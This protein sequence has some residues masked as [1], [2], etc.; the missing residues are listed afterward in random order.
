MPRGLPRL[1]LRLRRL[2]QRRSS[3]LKTRMRT[4][5][6][7]LAGPAP[8]SPLLPH[9]PLAPHRPP[10][11]LSPRPPHASVSIL[12]PLHGAYAFAELAGVAT[13]M[14]AASVRRV[15][16]ARRGRCTCE[17][18]VNPTSSGSRSEAAACSAFGAGLFPSS[19]SHADRRQE[20]TTIP[21]I[22]GQ[23]GFWPFVIFLLLQRT[24]M[25]ITNILFI[26]DYG[27][28]SPPSIVSCLLFILHH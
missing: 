2:S 14:A 4:R 18:R 5:R 22:W 21:S 1:R 16:T 12:P 7:A 15:F 25:T 13:I 26:R 28:C 8:P 23:F 19:F 24:M 10:R 27:A 6:S 17:A 11:Q 3:I 9:Q 20:K